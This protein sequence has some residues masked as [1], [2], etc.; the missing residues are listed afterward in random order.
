VPFVQCPQKD[1]PSGTGILGERETLNNHRERGKR[2]KD[3]SA[4]TWGCQTQKMKKCPRQKKEMWEKPLVFVLGKGGLGG[5]KKGIFGSDPVWGAMSPVKS[6]QSP[7]CPTR[8][9]WGGK[10][11]KR[12]LFMPKKTRPGK[13]GGLRSVSTRCWVGNILAHNSEEEGGAKPPHPPEK[14]DKKNY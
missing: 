11:E 9:D 10:K 7:G 2:K 8:W 5:G 13:V 6:G 14:R 4:S 1:P 3:Y 12:K